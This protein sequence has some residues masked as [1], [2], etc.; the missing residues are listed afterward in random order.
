MSLPEI[1]MA[2]GVPRSTV[3]G[4]LADIPL[5]AEETQARRSRNAIGLS[6]YA[7]QGAQTAREQRKALQSP[8]YNETATSSMSTDEKGSLAE[9]A[10]TYFLKSQGLD[11]YTTTTP[12]RKFDLL[13]H[14]ILNDRFLKIQVKTISY[15]RHGSG[16]FRLKAR[17]SRGTER[18]TS[19]DF[20]YIIGYCP[21]TSRCYVYSSTELSHLKG[22]A[23]PT[24]S[25]LNAWHKLKQA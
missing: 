6:A 8:T 20:D 7:R 23:T 19:R 12:G 18:Y 2:T 21:I 15:G 25:A 16:T 5:T 14:D 10:V 17:R 11:V 4:H 1:V 24:L 22:H 3:N 9:S 13:V